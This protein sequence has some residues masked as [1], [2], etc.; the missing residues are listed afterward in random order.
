MEPKQA[1]YK[2]DGVER[3]FDTKSQ[4]VRAPVIRPEQS[5]DAEAIRHVTFEAFR[6]MPFADGDEHELIGV[7]RESGALAVS[8][9]A[10]LDGTIIGHIAFSPATTADGSAGWY[11]LGPVSVLPEFQGVG[12]GS[13]LIIG[14]I[15]RIETLGGRGCIL[16]GDP[17]YYV[18]FGFR[19][20]PEL[21]PANEPAEYFMIKAIGS[22]MPHGPF[23]FHEAFCG[24][25]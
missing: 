7:L 20:A 15:Q 23:G 17:N 12:I 6:G 8:L 10:D 11:A 19:P 13:A 18:R 4:N 21:A 9:V 5:A 14:G 2:A 1:T 3:I 24:T 25:A 16:T 22:S